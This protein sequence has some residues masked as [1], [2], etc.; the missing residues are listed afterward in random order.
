MRSLAVYI[1]LLLGFLWMPS[2]LAQS[3]DVVVITHPSTP[4]E[5]LDQ[6]MLYD[7]FT[8]DRLYWKNGQAVTVFDLKKRDD[9]KEAF[10]EHF[11][12]KS[13]SRLKSVWLKKKLMGEGNPPE[14]LDSAQE[15][16]ERVTHT[17]GAIGYVA[18]GEVLAGVKVLA[19][20]SSGTGQPITTVEAR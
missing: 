7:F 18:R 10:Y 12:G 1:T 20:I 8:R 4:V 5:S 16:I 14:A 2:V 11:L 15:V 3:A 13:P 9:V 19:I 17:V 6:Q